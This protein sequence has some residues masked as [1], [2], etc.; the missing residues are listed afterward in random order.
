MSTAQKCMMCNQGEWTELVKDLATGFVFC[1]DCND[2]VE[3]EYQSL[4][5]TRGLANWLRAIANIAE[6]KEV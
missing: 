3:K 1:K 6:K 2:E 4:I 5:G